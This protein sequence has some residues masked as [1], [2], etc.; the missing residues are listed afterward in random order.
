[1]FGL[2]PVSDTGFLKPLEFPNLWEPQRCLVEVTFEKH[3]KMGAGCQ[4]N[5]L[6]D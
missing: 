4:D 2:C 6:S 1:M 3:L 5:Q